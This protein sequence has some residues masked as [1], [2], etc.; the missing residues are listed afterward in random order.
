DFKQQYTLNVKAKTEVVKTPKVWCYRVGEGFRMSEFTVRCNYEG[1][2]YKDFSG[3]ELSITANGNK[4][5]EGYKFQQAGN[6]NLVVKYGDYSKKYTLTVVD[7]NSPIMEMIKE[8]LTFNYR[9][10][11][12]FRMS[13]YVVRCNYPDGTTKDFTGSDLTITANGVT[14]SEGY[15]FKQ[16]G[17][18]KLIVKYGDFKQQ[19][20][21]K[22]KNAGEA[23]EI[24]V[25]VDGNVVKFDQQ[26]VIK[27]DRTLVPLRA[28][29]TE[30]GASVDWNEDTETVTAKKDNTVVT[31]QIG[32]TN[33][34]V[35]NTEK[36]LD[37]PA[38]LINSRTLIPVRAVAESFDCD[39]SWNEDIR[40]VEIIRNDASSVNNPFAELAR[41]VLYYTNVE[42]EKQGLDAL[43]WD[44][45]V[46][47]V[48]QAYSENMATN[49]FL[50][51]EG[52]DGSTPVSRIKDAGISY[53]AL[54]ENVG[55]GTETAKDIVK[56]W[57]NSEGHKAN[58]LNPDYTHLGVGVS[59]GDNG[60]LFWTQNFLAY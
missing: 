38:Q 24:S 26:P 2:N 5:Y 28:I 21:L 56:E 55:M 50:A 45:D 3:G 23:D 25:T 34:K 22:V 6:K 42:R 48:A 44:D 14:L 35:N 15:E 54:G 58:I 43:T 40:V 37:V 11:E 53:K 17:S 7:A 60:Y 41:D 32:N 33:Y 10:G 47:K 46:A 51:H 1:G 18:K 8:P 20:T 13:D 52:T 59:R 16:A 9:V 39:V 36:T 57:M 4:M 49:Y 29:F 31:M 12:G 19:Y 30:L 27:D